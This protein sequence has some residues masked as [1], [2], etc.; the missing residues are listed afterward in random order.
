MLVT[1]LLGEE[2]S[3]LEQTLRQSR[4]I[5][6]LGTVAVSGLGSPTWLCDL[7]PL[8][9][10]PAT[11]ALYLCMYVFIYLFLFFPFFRLHTWAFESSWARGHI[12]AVAAGLYHSHSNRIQAACVTYT[13]A[14]SNTR[15]LTH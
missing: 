1:R 13:A 5:R 9:W 10:R 14:R 11:L 8:G 2:G 15:S 6:Y 3:G 7:V 12:R 4:R